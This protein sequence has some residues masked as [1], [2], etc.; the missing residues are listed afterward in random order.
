M[1]GGLVGVALLLAAGCLQPTGTA[2]SSPAP[3]SPFALLP[4]LHLPD[5]GAPLSVAATPWGVAVADERGHLWLYRPEDG[6]VTSLGTFPQVDGEGGMQVAW[7][8]TAL[9][10]R[11]EQEDGGMC[12]GSR[13]DMDLQ[14]AVRTIHYVAWNRSDAGPRPLADGPS[15]QSCGGSDVPRIGGVFAWLGDAGYVSYPSGAFARYDPVAGEAALDLPVPAAQALVPGNG[16]TLYALGSGDLDSWTSVD[17]RTGASPG[18]LR[19]GCS[20]DPAT[21]MGWSHGGTLA[22][23][24]L[25]A[26]CTHADRVL[27]PTPQGLRVFAGAAPVPLRGHHG[28]ATQDGARD[29]LFLEDGTVLSFT[30]RGPPVANAPPA[31]SVAGSRHGGRLEADASGSHDPEGDALAITW[32]LDTQRQTGPTWSS[33]WPD[34]PD[35]VQSFLV[36]TATDGYGAQAAAALVVEPGQPDGPLPAAA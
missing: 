31:V 32:T 24:N 36:A 19:L 23:A 9:V 14:L 33:A 34:Q 12:E 11:Y 5:G 6:N 29:L 21:T 22:E 1:R 2:P 26:P 25:D 27:A 7:N 30:P 18:P 10:L 35:G 28:A 13:P 17:V 4:P 16:T 20:L 3:A 15:R 8:G